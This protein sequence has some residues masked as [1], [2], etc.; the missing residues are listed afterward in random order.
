MYVYIY[1]INIQHSF[2]DYNIYQYKYHLFIICL[3]IKFINI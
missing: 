2:I 3:Y 1:I